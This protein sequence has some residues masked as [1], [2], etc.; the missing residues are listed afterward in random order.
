MYFQRLDT[1]RH[2]LL[3]VTQLHDQLLGTITKETDH[4]TALGDLSNKA[5]TE[6]RSSMDGIVQ[7]NDRLYVQYKQALAISDEHQRQ[8]QV[9]VAKLG[10][11][12]AQVYQLQK[13]NLEL[14]EKYATTIADAPSAMGTT[15]SNV[16][17]GSLETKLSEAEEVKHVLE[18]QL[19]ATQEE[20]ARASGNTR[21]KVWLHMVDFFSCRSHPIT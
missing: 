15:T 13:I 11:A 12:E 20:L 17:S 16:I 19:V 1:S 10:S 21:C 9:V 3:K 4:G 18:N 7:E 2:Q 14:E 5:V 6:L 8:L